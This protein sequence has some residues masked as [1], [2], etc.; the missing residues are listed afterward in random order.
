MTEDIFLSDSAAPDF[1]FV[2]RQHQGKDGKGWRQSKDEYAY[3]QPVHSDVHIL[4]SAWT[5]EHVIKRL[6]EAFKTDRCVELKKPR[7]TGGSP[8]DVSYSA[9]D[10]EGW[11]M[12]EDIVI[13]PSK[14]D[15]ER[16]EEAFGWITAK[17]K[18]DPT[19]A[20]MLRGLCIIKASKWSLSRYCR[21]FHTDR[22]TFRRKAESA[23]CDIAD[24][25]S[26]CRTPVT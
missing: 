19:G 23:A 3:V 15:F 11:L 26:A 24:A 5:G 12:T 8:P 22:R 13:G 1:I 9:E 10:R 6:I 18:I 2:D 25:L 7:A 21:D 17:F 20:M 16:M 14:L 4:P